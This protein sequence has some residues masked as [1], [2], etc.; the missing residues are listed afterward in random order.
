MKPRAAAGFTLL[1][2]MI[3]VILLAILSLGVLA[4]FAMASK[5]SQE[6]SEHTEGGVQAQQT[7]ERNRNH[8][9]CDDAGWFD[10]NCNPITQ[11]A[12]ND[13][14]G[15]GRL[16]ALGGTRNYTAAP[17]NCGGIAGDCVKVQVNVNWTPPQ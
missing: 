1:E 13:A 2:V 10:A 15:A 4:S 9:A 14:I 6:S 8:V 3:S 16:P 12:T 5:I 17:D 11:A 7:I